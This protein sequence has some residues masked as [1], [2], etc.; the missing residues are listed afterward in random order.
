MLLSCNQE[1]KKETIEIKQVTG[2]VS[3]YNKDVMYLNVLRTGLTHPLR[4]TEQTKMDI[5]AA[6]LDTVVLRYSGSLGY[7]LVLPVIY[8]VK[9]RPFKETGSKVV[10][11]N[12]LRKNSGELQTCP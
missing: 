5:L 12:E 11:L 4:V 1:K 3:G 2:I 7:T 8:E 9:T 6:P 10:N